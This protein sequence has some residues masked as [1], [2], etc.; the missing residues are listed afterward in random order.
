VR[1]VILRKLVIKHER[2]AHGGHLFSSPAPRCW[3]FLSFGTDIY[4]F[5]IGLG[6]LHVD[7]ENREK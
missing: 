1:D 5:H 6:R 7:I 4:L 2:G 3:F